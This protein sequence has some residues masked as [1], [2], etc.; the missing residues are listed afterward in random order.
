MYILNF[1]IY[2]YLVENGRGMKD[3]KILTKNPEETVPKTCKLLKI[4]FEW[5]I[6]NKIRISIFYYE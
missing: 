4:L 3:R 2:T 1:T 5:N 6:N